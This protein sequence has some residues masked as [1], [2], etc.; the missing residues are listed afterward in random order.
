MLARSLCLVLALAP[1]AGAQK[2]AREPVEDL[3]N[4]FRVTLP[5]WKGRVLPAGSAEDGVLCLFADTDSR[6]FRVQAMVARL[7]EPADATQGDATVEELV[8]LAS[9]LLDERD[10]GEWLPPLS[11][12]AV[13][14]GE[15]P[16]R[17]VQLRW[18]ADWAEASLLVDAW[19]IRD[20]GQRLALLFSI[21]TPKP[22]PSWPRLIEKSARTFTLLPRVA[23]GSELSYDQILEQERAKVARIP[24]WRALPTPSRKFVILTSHT[25][26]RFVK[27][28]VERLELSRELYERDF[29]A[30]EDF[31]AVSIVRLCSSAREFHS[32]GSTDHRSGVVGWFSPQTTEMVLYDAKD[33]D[34]RMS[35]AV[36]THEAFHQ[37]CHYLFDRAPSPRWFDEG[38]GDYYG[39]FRWGPRGK[40]EVRT[41]MPGGLDRLREIQLMV[42]GGG[43]GP[44][45]LHL[46]AGSGPWQELGGYAQ[47]WSIVYMLR[48]GMRGQVHR[49]VWREEYA[50]ILPDYVAAMRAG[51]ARAC[52]DLRDE[53]LKAAEEEGR[54]AT[55]EELDIHGDDVSEER[56]LEIWE[57][58]YEASWGRIDM[59]RFEADWKLFVEKY[60]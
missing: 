46:Q 23:P 60:I 53:R 16:A 12:E 57:S 31:R 1:A 58:A 42:Q 32:Y 40:P 47:S 24:G 17:H 50:S 7:P 54:A 34:R 27:E 33:I 4:G 28:V 9:W 43:Y 59:A 38:H 55:A 30:P 14:L 48:E 44:L 19:C 25:D 8:A 35:F 49:K 36:M 45:D 39:A 51:F 21:R 10:E 3:V 22:G 18:N 11:D 6:M 37:Y 20:D 13:T 5:E 56:V 41:Q 52:S 2:L 29:P 15:Q 26:D